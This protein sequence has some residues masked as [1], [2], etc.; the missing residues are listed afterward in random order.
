MSNISKDQNSGCW[1]WKGYKDRQGYGSISLN[2]YPTKVH[3]IMFEYKFF[4]LGDL[5][6]CHT[7]DN[8]SCVNPDHLFAGTRKDNAID[9]LEKG[10][11]HQANKTHC[12]KGHE[13]SKKNTGINNGSRYCKQCNN[14][15]VKSKYI[16][17]ARRINIKIQASIP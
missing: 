11:H 17:K 16:T 13:Y 10:R 7:C 9:M 3:R 2:C 15:N 14:I 4:K 12:P 1:N 6:C 5:I 8:P